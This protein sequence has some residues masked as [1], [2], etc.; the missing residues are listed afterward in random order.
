MWVFQNITLQRATKI[1]LAFHFVECKNQLKMASR[2]VH[3]NQ[4]FNGVNMK[5]HNGGTLGL[6]MSPVEMC[7]AF[8]KLQQHRDGTFFRILLFTFSAIKG[9]VKE[10][11]LSFTL[12]EKYVNKIHVFPL[13]SESI[14]VSLH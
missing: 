6:G 2:F 9:P 12:G 10:L 1:R 5:L 11:R 4:D 7:Q 13:F 3:C 14:Q 8:Q